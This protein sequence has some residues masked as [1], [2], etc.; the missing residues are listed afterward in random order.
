[1]TRTYPKEDISFG[2]VLNMSVLK[3]INVYPQGN[4]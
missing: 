2:W 4:M 3:E 1:M